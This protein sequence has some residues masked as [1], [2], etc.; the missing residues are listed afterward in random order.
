[1]N[2]E[3]V[4]YPHTAHKPHTTGPTLANFSVKYGHAPYARGARCLS[5]SLIRN[6]LLI[7]Q[8]YNGRVYD[9]LSPPHASQ[10]QPLKVLASAKPATTG[11]TEED[12]EGS[13]HTNTSYSTGKT[14]LSSFSYRE[15]GSGSRVVG[16]SVHTVYSPEQAMELLRKGAQNRRVRS[17]EVHSC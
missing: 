8:V 11:C 5:Y 4:S 13:T 1:M 10:M 9:L 16:L 6:L 7:S 14:R 15:N 2:M 17:T 12:I 3:L